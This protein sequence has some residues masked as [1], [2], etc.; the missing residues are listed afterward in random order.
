LGGRGRRISEFKANLVYKVSSRT[1]RATQRNPVW[2]KN[3]NKNKKRVSKAWEL[4]L[5]HTHTHTHT[6][7]SSQ[8]LEF[9][10]RDLIVLPGKA[11]VQKGGISY[12]KAHLF[13]RTDRQTALLRAEEGHLLPR[14]LT[15]KHKQTKQNKT[16]RVCNQVACLTPVISTL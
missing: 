7:P 13:Y 16:L 9:G 8:S 11:G 14:C 1:A 2:K 15:A 6:Q 3:K 4:K 12:H 10:P 5:P